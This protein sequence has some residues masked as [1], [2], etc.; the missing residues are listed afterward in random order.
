MWVGDVEPRSDGLPPVELC[1]RFMHFYRI[2]DGAVLSSAVLAGI[3][4]SP[5]F[6]NR[7]RVWKRRG[8][9]TMVNQGDLT[10]HELERLL[11]DASRG[12][13]A[14]PSFATI[15]DSAFSRLYDAWLVHFRSAEG[16]PHYPKSFCDAYE[17]WIRVRYQNQ[18]VMN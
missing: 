15:H 2:N 16:R 14:E 7:A 13:F 9:L 12:K 17:K 4:P 18:D 3:H 5:K 10:T 1:R 8:I 6:L 11:Y